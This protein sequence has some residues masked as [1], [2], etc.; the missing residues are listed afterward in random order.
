[1]TA[2]A[3]LTDEQ[4]VRL[5]EQVAA[6][7]RPRVRVSG[8]QFPVGTAGAVVRVGDPETDGA[9]FVTVRVKVGG[10]TDEL[11]FAPRELSTAGRVAAPRASRR[12][13]SGPAP[14]VP[15]APAASPRVAQSAPPKRKAP[16]KPDR[17]A[18]P[19]PTVT[20][21]I[22]SKGAAWTVTAQRGARTVA[23]GVAVP[24]GVVAAVAT[25]LGQVAVEEAVAAVNDAAL[26]EAQARADRLRAELA[27]VEA[28]LSSHRRP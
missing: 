2:R 1:M 7:R 23:K 6:G 9:D 21:T 22:A 5:R 25:L 24:P 18:G 26:G 17:R 15:A 4:I 11:G 10:I 3:G 14:S 8:P 27:D 13:P 16:S 12:A 19:V 28:V 20:I